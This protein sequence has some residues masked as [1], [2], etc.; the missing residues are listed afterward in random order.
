[1]QQKK[2]L[3]PQVKQSGVFYLKFSCNFVAE[4][5]GILEQVSAQVKTIALFRQ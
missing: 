2:L 4:V 1:M 3:L 5:L